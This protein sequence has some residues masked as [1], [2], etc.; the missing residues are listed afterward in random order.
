MAGIDNEES[1]ATTSSTR[2]RSLSSA[3]AWPSLD[4]E[5]GQRLRPNLILA[6]LY[7]RSPLDVDQVRRLMHERL[8]Q[9][10]VRFRSIPRRGDGNSVHLDELPP[11]AIDMEHHVQG[12]PEAAGWTQTDI[13][14]FLS[15]EYAATKDVVRPLWRFYVLNGLADGRSCL[16][17]NI[18]HCIGDGIALVQVFIYLHLFI[19]APIYANILYISYACTYFRPCYR[20]WTITTQ[21]QELLLLIVLLPPLLVLLA[22]RMRTTR[23]SSSLAKAAIPSTPPTHIVILIPMV[24]VIVTRGRLS[25]GALGCTPDGTPHATSSKVRA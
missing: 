1:K 9:R 10:H 22:A 24:I 3:F 17:V 15:S 16:F 19:Y 18:D 7:F 2:A 21:Q 23:S 25:R 20:C 14:A 5:I 11:A 6:M 13:D 12:V 4:P 8:V